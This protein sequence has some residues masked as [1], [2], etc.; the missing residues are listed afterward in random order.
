M[1]VSRLRKSALHGEQ[2]PGILRAHGI[3]GEGKRK[4]SSQTQGKR[5]H[6]NCC[7]SSRLLK[8][9]FLH[10]NQHHSQKTSRSDIAGPQNPSSQGTGVWQN[11]RKATHATNSH[12]L[13][14]P[15]CAVWTAHN[16]LHHARSSPFTHIIA[17]VSQST[18]TGTAKGLSALPTA[19]ASV[20][21]SHSAHY[22]NS[23]SAATLRRAA[24][25]WASSGHPHIRTHAVEPLV[26]T[27]WPSSGRKKAL[28]RTHKQRHPRRTARKIHAQT[29]RSPPSAPSHP[30]VI[31]ERNTSGRP[32]GTSVPL[33]GNKKEWRMSAAKPAEEQSTEHG[34]TKWKRKRQKK[35]VSRSALQ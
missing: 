9:N 30:R 13:L 26:L 18:T 5:I 35:K 22:N 34:D 6:T 3:H 16:S 17:D 11:V 4:A 24:Q 31:A 25:C 10:A 20:P 32:H 28:K 2:L 23:A 14:Q 7:F 12:S 21:H 8:A 1:A 19:E 27:A 33:A 15:Q 29:I